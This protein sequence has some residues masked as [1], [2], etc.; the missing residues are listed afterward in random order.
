MTITA[1]QA[2]TN[3]KQWFLARM[4]V[5]DDSN[6][7]SRALIVECASWQPSG[8]TALDLTDDAESP[9]IIVGFINAVMGYD[10]LDGSRTGVWKGDN[11]LALLAKAG[12]GTHDPGRI[13]VR[14]LSLKEALHEYEPGS[15]GW[16]RR[17]L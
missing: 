8:G 4:A 6:A 14:G 1:A 7:W 12:V 9:P 13:E 11:H 16:I 10:P 15:E 17:H 2:K 3:L 5:L